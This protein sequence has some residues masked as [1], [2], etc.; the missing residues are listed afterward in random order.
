LVGDA[1]SD[2]S[3]SLGRRWLAAGLCALNGLCSLGECA[4]EG[5]EGPASICP[6]LPAAPAAAGPVGLLML[7]VVR[8]SRLGTL[9]A[10]KGPL[11]RSA[12]GDDPAAAA[13][14]CACTAKL[15]SP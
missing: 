3:T 10:G 15:G 11:L 5:E 1:G 6:A 13:C 9:H 8:P 12:T 4:L 14:C 7:P 2:K